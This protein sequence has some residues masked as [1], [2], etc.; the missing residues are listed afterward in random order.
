MSCD[1]TQSVGVNNYHS[2]ASVFRKCLRSAKVKDRSDMTMHRR[3]SNSPCKRV[4]DKLQ[5]LYFGGVEIEKEGVA[6]I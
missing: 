3:S 5:T 1:I 4:L 2:S 6:V